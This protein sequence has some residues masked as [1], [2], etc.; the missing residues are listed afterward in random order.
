MEE[1]YKTDL[2]KI[3]FP[4]LILLGIIIAGVFLVNALLGRIQSVKNETAT[5]QK[6][7][8]AL[9]VKLS[10]LQ[11]TQDNGLIDSQELFN[12]FPTQNPSS[13][14][15]SQIKRIASDFGVSLGQVQTSVAA[16]KNTNIEKVE[17]SLSAEGNL[18]GILNFFG[19]IP[20][21]APLS[22]L[23]NIKLV[24]TA[25]TIKATGNVTYY[26]SDV[27]KELPK[28]SEAITSFTEDEVKIITFLNSLTNPNL[29]TVDF[30]GETNGLND[31][32]AL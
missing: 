21:F 6:E 30:V 23:K 2:K 24:N 14:A 20:K 29:G 8:T 12:A 19:A 22:S 7:N 32:F 16:S 28:I 31:P 26:W 11:E 3:A 9:Q 25:G 15:V 13:A 10:T 1:I 17:V 27:P 4:L 5:A 18:T